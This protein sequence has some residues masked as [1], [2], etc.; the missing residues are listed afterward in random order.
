M[1]LAMA[2]CTSSGILSHG[3]SKVLCHLLDMLADCL[4]LCEVHGVEGSEELDRDEM[5]DSEDE[6]QGNGLESEVRLVCVESSGKTCRSSV[7]VVDSTTHGN[8]IYY[9]YHYFT[10]FATYACK[11]IS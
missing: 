2:D 8:K 1:L 11:L 5:L 6:E 10:I 3:T 4:R 9:Y 7:T